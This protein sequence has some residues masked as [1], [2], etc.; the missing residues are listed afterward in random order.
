MTK[1]KRPSYKQKAFAKAYIKN[2]GNATDAAIETLDVTTHDSAKH[3]GMAM[4]DRP[5]VQEEIHKLLDKAGLSLDDLTNYS[6]E[7][8]TKGLE[9]K[10]S[11]NTAASH[12]EKLYKLHGATGHDKNVSVK[13][14]IKQQRGNKSIT[15]IT[16][17]INK[18]HENI[19]KLLK[20]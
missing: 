15:E 9:A 19:D 3:S 17:N 2:G 13:W 20:A 16:E 12:V 10:P 18:L 4:L 8:I 7:I 6:R 5:M 14:S 1:L 11:F